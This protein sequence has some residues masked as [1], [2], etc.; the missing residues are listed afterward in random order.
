MID[1]AKLRGQFDEEVDEGQAH[2]LERI[3]R[4]R[5]GTKTA[6]YQ[7]SMGIPTVGIGHKVTAADHLEVGDVISDDRVSAL[8]RPDAQ[9]ALAAARIQAIEAGIYDRDF[10]PALSLG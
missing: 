3:L 10:I 6:V 7:D 4:Q 8:Y 5:E 9:S 1:M 2:R